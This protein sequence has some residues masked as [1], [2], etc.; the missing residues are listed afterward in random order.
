[1]IRPTEAL[2]EAAADRRPVT[3]ARR[4]LGLAC[5]V[6]AAGALAAVA[7]AFPQAA[8][9]LKTDVELALLLVTAAAT[10]APLAVPALVRAAT[11]PLARGA[12]ATLV[13]GSVLTQPRRCAATVAPWLITVALAAAVLGS[14]DTAG[15][16]G[17]RAL[18]DQAAAARFVV[19][20][21][22]GSHTLTADALA[23][24]AGA[25]TT[26]AVTDPTV[27]AHQPAL[28]RLHFEAPMPIPFPA[29]G[30]DRPDLLHLPV[31]H[32]SLADLAENTVAV[33]SSWHKHVGDTLTLWLPD[34]RPAVLRVIAVLQAGPGIAPVVLN[35]K[36]TGRALP[37]RAYTRP[38]PGTSPDA[39]RG[40]LRAA[41]ADLRPTAAWTASVTDRQAAQ[42]RLGLVVLLGISLGYSAIASVSSFATLVAGRR[43]ELETL[44]LS[45]AV[46]RQIVGGAA[47]EAA[48]LAVAATVLAALVAA[49][50][51]A[52]MSLA[53]AGPRTVAPVVAPWPL[54]A[55][56]AATGT[57]VA[58]AS[59]ALAAALATRP[60][61]PAS[62][63][64]A[65][66]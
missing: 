59:A 48:A 31:T 53:L 7:F 65:P 12:T 27:L 16:A 62:S 10:L 15:A 17:D 13:R 57:A 4:V 44:R 47:A 60:Q 36:D 55:A 37:D 46:R 33:D 18:H 21:A 9:D 54:L 39:L 11:R 35:A 50:Q 3:R 63:R 56:I 51:L 6:C 8:S 66:H 58:V 43:R 14:A 19:T 26:T 30:V 23:A 52:A 64:P 2:R 20:P 25:A 41:G 34:G 1:M 38:R 49:A 22:A 45:G 5:L 42:S 29:I 24:L 28:T 32:G 61:R 40:A